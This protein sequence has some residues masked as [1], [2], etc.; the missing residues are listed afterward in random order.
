MFNINEFLK[1]RKLE[2][3]YTKL[4]SL[5]YNLDQIFELLYRDYDIGYE[6]VYGKKANNFWKLFTPEQR[7]EILKRIY[8]E[9]FFKDNILAR[10]RFIFY[11]I[12]LENREKYLNKIFYEILSTNDQ[13]DIQNR[14]YYISN[15][16]NEDRFNL[17]KD[18][19]K[20]MFKDNNISSISNYMFKVWYDSDVNTIKRYM[21]LFKEDGRFFDLS[22]E[23]LYKSVINMLFRKRYHTEDYKYLNELILES[24]SYLG[25]K[26]IVTTMSS[27]IKLSSFALISNVIKNKNMF[28]SKVLFYIID[29]LKSVYKDGQKLKDFY[30]SNNEDLIALADYFDDKID[31]HKLSK[32]INFEIPYPVIGKR[33][34]DDDF[35]KMF[36]N[37]VVFNDHFNKEAYINLIRYLTKT[38]MNIFHSLSFDLM[39]PKYLEIFEE[40]DENGN[41]IYP[42]LRVIGKYHNLQNA[43]LRLDDE[44]LAIF[45]IIYKKL[46]RDDYDY[47]VI[48]N[49]VLNNLS[50]NQDKLFGIVKDGYDNLNDTD[51]DK[52]IDSL[53]FIL[54]KGSYKTFMI[55]SLNDLIDLKGH[56]RKLYVDA[57]NS[58][59][60]VSGLLNCYLLT[61]YGLT[62][63]EAKSLISSFASDLT[64]DDNL[65]DESDKKIISSL[66]SLK[67]LIECKNLDL[68]RK[69]IILQENLCDDS[70]DF[71]LAYVASFEAQV[72]KVFT[73]VFN[74]KL[75]DPKDMHKYHK[76]SKRMGVNVYNGIDYDN[77][78]FFM[79]V[80]ALGAY[81]NYEK[82]DNYY[83]DWVRPS[84]NVHAFCSSLISNQMMGI[85]RANYA[86]LGFRDVPE[87]SLL[88]AAPYDIASS[89]ANGL[90][91]TAVRTRRKFLFPDK[92]IDYTRHTHNEITLERLYKDGKY[93]PSY[94]LYITESFIPD[95]PL[96]DEI[97]ESLTYVNQGLNAWKNTLQAARDFNVPIVVIDRSVVKKHEIALINDKVDEFYETHN[98]NLIYDILTRFENN[99]A[100]TRDY[101][102]G[103]GFETNDAKM[104]FTRLFSIIDGIKDKDK[105]SFCLMEMRRWLNDE[106][107]VKV[108]RKGAPVGDLE[109]GIDCK[110][111]LEK[112]KKRL[113]KLNKVNMTWKD[114]INVLENV[115]IQ[116]MDATLKIDFLRKY[117]FNIE[118]SRFDYLEDNQKGLIYLESVLKDYGELIPSLDDDIDRKRAYDSSLGAHGKDH[119]D[120]V[121]IYAL[122]LAYEEF[123]DRED[124]TLLI[125][126]A[127]TCAKYH[128]CGRSDDGNSDHALNG[129][130]KAYHLLKE[131][132]LYSNTVLAAIYSAIVCHDLKGIDEPF[133]SYC[134]KVYSDALMAIEREYEPNSHIEYSDRDFIDV[135]KKYNASYNEVIDNIKNITRILRD[136]DALD[137][138][139]FM[140]SSNAFTKQSLLSSE[141][142]R[143][144]N[145]AI[146]LSEFNALSNIQKYLNEG[147]IDINSILNILDRPYE[148]QSNPIKIEGP[149]DLEKIIRTNI[150]KTQNESRLRDGYGTEKL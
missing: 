28:D 107:S 144:M 74:K 36:A 121:M 45:K 140:Q 124:A 12:D 129:A 106:T 16:N 118:A 90:M 136:A 71:D 70:F 59:G 130:I 7:L 98:P 38:N 51:K 27:S 146:R 142:R 61:Y 13:K 108:G 147:L 63:D 14:L 145:L 138:T 103:Y 30:R 80:S 95:M 94:V 57:E 53:I 9:N 64:V 113:V 88:L 75:S 69:K 89:T 68:L 24:V 11:D 40:L 91:D 2:H 105:A 112:I 37:K 56:L 102:N 100:G 1:S 120:D 101:W 31:L 33:F 52:V 34:N 8:L 123:K 46:I 67:E 48:L 114:A 72:R 92:M 79:L 137:R 143:Y 66:K 97:P 87:S 119:V 25:H 43:I 3:T 58:C 86:V 134:V 10:F 133:D 135:L 65:L 17:I 60:V 23:Y 15:L 49:N 41:R 22:A 32:I 29:S 127:V 128:D 115:N 96:E 82:P 126:A 149:K 122:L 78:N 4:V 117:G 150:Y 26:G 20:M 54:S 73:K 83:E 116:D 125:N 85:A 131:K 47:T 111:T 141:G 5:G 81:T 132:K 50:F 109:L 99:R 77:P 110:K 21:V 35:D 93:L 44:S 42:S 139:R 55:E 39:Q 76:L 19:Y 104:L 84:N 18:N 6:I 148:Y 62:L